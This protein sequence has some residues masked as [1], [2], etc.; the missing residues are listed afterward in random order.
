M[1]RPYIKGGTPLGSQPLCHTCASAHIMTGYRESE[2]IILCTDV[3]PNIVLPFVI[4]ECTG[5]YDKNRPSWKQMEDLAIEVRPSST[6][7]PVGFKVGI[8]F[9]AEREDPETDEAEP[10]IEVEEQPAALANTPGLLL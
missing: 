10:E 3:H 7:K 8:G 9:A 4:H 1:S 5:Y 2:Q 6:L